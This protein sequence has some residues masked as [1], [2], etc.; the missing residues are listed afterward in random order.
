VRGVL[1]ARTVLAVTADQRPRLADVFCD[2]VSDITRALSVEG[3]ASFVETFKNL[4]FYGPCPDHGLPCLVTAPPGTPCSAMDTV[5]L[6]GEPIALLYLDVDEASA[7]V[8][9]ITHVEVVDGRDL[10]VPA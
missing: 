3:P 7:T 8:T 5:E 10:G 1:R 9:A 4:P 2:L 6:D